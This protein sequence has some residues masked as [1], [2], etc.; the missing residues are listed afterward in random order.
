[1]DVTELAQFVR[2]T[3][4]FSEV[5][6]VL[7]KYG[8]VGW[9]HN[10]GLNWV[11]QFFQDTEGHPLAALTLEERSRLALIEL[12]P[13]YIKLGQILSTRPDLVGPQLAKNSPSC[14]PIRPRTR[15]KWYERRLR[16]NSDD[17]R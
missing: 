13:A 5:V 11:Q 9:L 6:S 15:R 12:G 7:A 10:V 2:N 17:R 16:L 4:R 14:A 8:L 1:M 3:S